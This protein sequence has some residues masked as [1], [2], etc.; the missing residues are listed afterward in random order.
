MKTPHVFWH[1]TWYIRK[2]IKT[3][4]ITRAWEAVRDE[5]WTATWF[6]VIPVLHLGHYGATLVSWG[7]ARTMTLK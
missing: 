6:D 5:A 3:D 7:A 1:D 2:F 4:K